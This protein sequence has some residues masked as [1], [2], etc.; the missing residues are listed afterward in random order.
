[1]CSKL[2]NAIFVVYARD[3][4]YIHIKKNHPFVPAT[5]GATG[6]FRTLQYA[7]FVVD[8]SALCLVSLI[9]AAR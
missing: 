7:V 2:P 4:P 3:G 9:V 8:F 5:I 1:M 6:L